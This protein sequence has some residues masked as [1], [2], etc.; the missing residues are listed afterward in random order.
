MEQKLKER[1]IGATVLVVDHEGY[2]DVAAQGRTV[3]KGRPRGASDKMGA[4][5]DIISLSKTQRTEKVYDVDAHMKHRGAAE[6]V[7]KFTVVFEREEAVHFVGP[8][9]P[10]T[11]GT[12]DEEGKDLLKHLASGAISSKRKLERVLGIKSP[13]R[14]D[15]LLTRFSV[16]VEIESHGKGKA[17]VPRL[18]A[19][20]H[21]LV[22]E[23]GFEVLNNGGAQNDVD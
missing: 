21:K 17:D 22:Q 14:L 16:L 6:S 19:K 10:H 5:D 4:V 23:L 15:N 13:T 11:A 8:E 18:T 1:L 20:G 2:G 3:A 7:E 9:S 12:L